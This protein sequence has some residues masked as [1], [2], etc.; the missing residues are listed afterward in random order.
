MAG[1]L[2]NYSKIDILRC[3]LRL[4]KNTSRQHLAKELEL[5]EGTIRTILNA[6]KSARLTD[7]AK[8]GHLISKEGAKLQATIYRH[9]SAPK[10][11][12]IRSIYPEYKKIGVVIKNSRKLSELY[13]LRDIAVKNNS[14]GAMILKFDKK[15]YAPES[16]Y[17]GDFS[18]FQKH[19]EFEEG[20]VLIIAFAEKIKNA[21]TGALAIAAELNSVLKKILENF[22]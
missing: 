21:E 15:L 22:E 20:D 8:S 9:I 16:G 6:L 5:G 1:S 13:K 2:P 14:E 11:L 18:E 10:K 7:S 17:N 19:F 3:F 12:E 4:D